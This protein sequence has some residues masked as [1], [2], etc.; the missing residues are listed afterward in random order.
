MSYCSFVNDRKKRWEG[1]GG[2]KYMNRPSFVRSMQTAS[3][4]PFDEIIYK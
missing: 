4:E 2:E 3:H 1:G